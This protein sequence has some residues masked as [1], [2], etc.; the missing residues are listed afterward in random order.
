MNNISSWMTYT[1]P[2]IPLHQRCIADYSKPNGT[3]QKTI[4]KRARY[5]RSQH[6]KRKRGRFA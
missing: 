2:Y 3:S 1:L 6:Q 5:I 4:R